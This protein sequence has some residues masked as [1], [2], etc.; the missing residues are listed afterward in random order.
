M[1]ITEREA[2]VIKEAVLQRDPVA[3]VYLFGSRTD[4]AKRGG[5]ID[6]LVISTRLDLMD[7]VR[8]EVDIEEKLGEIDMD[9]IVKKDAEDTFVKL[10][11]EEGAILL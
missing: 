3:R 10:V 11:L 6:I 9:L 2:I 8:I 1:R 5:D 4:D 7:A